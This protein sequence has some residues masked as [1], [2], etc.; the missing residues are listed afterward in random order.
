[1]F[2]TI[3]IS[4]GCEQ[5]NAKC[6]ELEINTTAPTAERAMEKLKKII[7]FYISTAKE[8]KVH[9]RCNAADLDHFHSDNFN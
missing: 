5:Y 4:K 6:V 1:M 8:D 2:L 7:D 3:E 9:A